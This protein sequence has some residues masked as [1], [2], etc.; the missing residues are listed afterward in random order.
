L[1]NLPQTEFVR[2]RIGIGRPPQGVDPAD[3]VLTPFDGEESSKI[4]EVVE[5]AADAVH[6]LI[7][8]GVSSTMELYNRVQ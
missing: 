7:E 5:R 2:V 6:S 1:E 8:N 3:F 4:E